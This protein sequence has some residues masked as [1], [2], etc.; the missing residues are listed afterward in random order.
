[1]GVVRLSTRFGQVCFKILLIRSSMIANQ[2]LLELR[3]ESRG[4]R[5]QLTASSSA[6]RALSRSEPFSQARLGSGFE[7]SAAGARGLEAGPC[8]SLFIFWH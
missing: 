4:L 6:S 2:L 8:T 5:A 3:L 1:M 7:G